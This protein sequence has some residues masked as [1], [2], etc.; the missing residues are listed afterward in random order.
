MTYR[1]KKK[2]L[3]IMI[4][5]GNLEK[6]KLAGM[7]GLAPIQIEQLLAMDI[8]DEKKA[9]DA[10]IRHDVRSLRRRK[11]YKAAQIK[12]V[13]AERYG[14]TIGCVSRNMRGTK[15]G[16][17]YYCIEC[18]KEITWKTKKKNMG[19]CEVCVASEIRET[20]D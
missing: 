7:T 3:E 8:I 10:I 20:L 12:S 9:L 16:L 18:G 14:V 2:H 6:E 17:R 15:T 19:R 13:L 5:F 4:K 11:I 1:R